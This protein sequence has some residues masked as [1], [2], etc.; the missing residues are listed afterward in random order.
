MEKVGRKDIKMVTGTQ[1]RWSLELGENWSRRPEE[2]WSQGIG[3]IIEIN[4]DFFMEISWRP[5][6]FRDMEIHYFFFNSNYDGD[7]IYEIYLI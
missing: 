6:E 2:D 7:I 3:N 5:F 4:G 1:R